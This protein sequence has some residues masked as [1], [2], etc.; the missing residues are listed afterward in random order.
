MKETLF[1]SKRIKWAL[2]CTEYRL[3]NSHYT[4]SQSGVRIGCE[5]TILVYTCTRFYSS[6]LILWHNG[7]LSTD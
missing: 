4:R 6:S 3:E 2:Y 1:I 5:L 7:W